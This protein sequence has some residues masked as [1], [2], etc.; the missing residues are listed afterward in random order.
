MQTKQYRV[1]RIDR[2]TKGTRKEKNKMEWKIYEKWLDVTLYRQMTDLIY[3]LS[4]KKEKNE[5][6]KAAS[7]QDPLLK[8]P[9]TDM[10]KE[11]GLH[12]PG[13]V[14]ERME[15]HQK[16][17]KQ[18]YRAL[19]LAL[20]RTLALQESFMFNGTQKITFFKKLERS[21]G[22][23]DLFFLSIRYRLEENNQGKWLDKLYQY[24]YQY[25]EETVLALSVLPEDEKLWELLKGKM[26]KILETKQN[27]Q[28]YEDWP[29]Y[30]WSAN[31][32]GDCGETTKERYLEILEFT[33]FVDFFSFNRLEE[34]HKE[35]VLVNKVTVVVALDLGTG[36]T[37]N[38]EL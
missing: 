19:G 20:A 12:Y 32:C 34:N 16:M 18:V 23:E 31:T 24:P 14:L 2:V 5:I 36:N 35:K 1:Y 26:A 38:P 33:H 30:V 7:R 13:E 4:N 28:V 27:L 29:I 15:E 11:Y 22:T 17:T 25:L 37:K 21:L 8:E 9:D 10:E 6:Y 3:R